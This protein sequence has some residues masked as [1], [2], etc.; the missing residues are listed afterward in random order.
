MPAVVDHRSR[1]ISEL[2]KDYSAVLLDLEA[3]T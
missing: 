2:K 1:I 3:R